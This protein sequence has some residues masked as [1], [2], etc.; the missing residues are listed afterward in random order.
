MKNIPLLL[1]SITLSLSALFTS[2]TKDTNPL[3]DPYEHMKQWGWDK[4]KEALGNVPYPAGSTNPF[5]T[6]ATHDE[7]TDR[8]ATKAHERVSSLQSKID[9]I[10]HHLENLK[11]SDILSHIKNLQSNRGHRKEELHKIKEA[12]RNALSDLKAIHRHSGEA[13]K[14]AESIARSATYF[15]E[16][17]LTKEGSQ[18]LGK[19][20]NKYLNVAKDAF[21][22]KKSPTT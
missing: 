8:F 10:H 22:G 11:H 5:D 12:A 3:N 1:G 20:V 17:H 21:K 7:R 6:H 13:A 19:M 2:Y 18:N 15:E 9:A 14:E 4:V 16:P